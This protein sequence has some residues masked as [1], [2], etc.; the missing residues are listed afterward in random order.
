MAWTC[1]FPNTDCNSALEMGRFC[2]APIQDATASPSPFSRKAET[3]FSNPPEPLINPV[4]SSTRPGCAPSI[5]LVNALRPALRL[6]QKVPFQFSLLR[7]ICGSYSMPTSYRTNQP[8]IA[9]KIASA[10]PPSFCRPP[11]RPAAAHS[12]WQP[13]TSAE[14]AFPSQAEALHPAPQAPVRR[15]PA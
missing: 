12:I 1:S 11:I 7:A 4:T 2:P 13:R 8:G 3:R 15:A 10:P 9:R 5:A 14:A 6:H